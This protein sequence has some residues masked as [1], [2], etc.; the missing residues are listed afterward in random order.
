M[1]A[2]FGY[3]SIREVEYLLGC[4]TMTAV[5]RLHYLTNKARVLTRF[6]SQLFPTH[7]YCLTP[8]GRRAVRDLALCDEIRDFTPSKYRPMWQNHDRLLIK[9]FI[10]FRRAFGER[11][12]GW[13]SELQLRREQFRGRVVDGEF[14]LRDGGDGGL[15]KCWVELELTLKSPARY[16]SQFK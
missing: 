7:F 14:F 6:E 16:R 15:L 2:K 11:F 3:I 10:A 8:H 9:C 1:A 12:A 13:T 5:H 4:D